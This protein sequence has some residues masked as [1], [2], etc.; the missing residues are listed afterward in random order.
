MPVTAVYDRERLNRVLGEQFGVVSRAQALGCGVS[1]GRLD[2]LVRPGGRWQRILPGVYVM[3]NGAVSVDQ[4]AMAALLYAGPRSLL[5]GAAAVRRHRLTCAGLN[6]VDVLVPEDVRVRSAGYV[7]IIRTGRMPEKC[8]RTER[9]RFALLPRA[10]ADAARPMTRL[11][12][13]RAVVAEAVQ[14]GRCD[15]AALVDELND[16]PVAGSRF[17]RAALRECIDGSRSAAEG[18]LMTLI[19]RS[20]LPEPMYNA[21]LYTADGT[22]L[23]VAD[24][25]WQRAGVAAEVD[26][27]RYHLSPADY[28][29]TVMRHNRMAAYGITML[30]FL[31][32]TV[33]AEPSTVVRA[34]RGAIAAGSARPPLPIVAKPSTPASGAGAAR[35]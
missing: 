30:H 20:G 12:D 33:K 31:P 19:G 7:R 8:C 1:R 11:S 18:E 6:L 22:F 13:V 15:L 5:T 21:E 26:S 14:N 9:I 34:L 10:V 27:R 25:W 4:R 24:A 28:E 23:G 16:G 29:R 3:T 2:H 32:G 35:L 17:Y